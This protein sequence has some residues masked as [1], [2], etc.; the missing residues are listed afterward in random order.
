MKIGDCDRVANAVNAA[1]FITFS[2][3]SFVA[4]GKNSL[5]FSTGTPFACRIAS[6]QNRGLR[7]SCQRSECRRSKGESEQSETGPSLGA[8]FVAP[9][10]NSLHFSTG[11]P[12]ACR[13]A[14]LQSHSI[15]QET[16]CDENRGLRQSCQR[17]ECRRSKGESEQSETGPSLGARSSRTSA[18]L[19]T[20]DSHT[21]LVAT[22]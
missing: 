14:S 7:Q 4:P 5:H 20:P 16:L 9:G 22:T 12:F 17:S 21:D 1:I 8:R 19:P 3:P 10:K 15:A 13:I 11:T 18:I 6:L 2:Y